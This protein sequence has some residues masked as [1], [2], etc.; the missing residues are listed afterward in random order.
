M[1]TVTGIVATLKSCELQQSLV[2]PSHP[3]LCLFLKLSC[4]KVR[5]LTLKFTQAIITGDTT[6]N[7]SIE[8]REEG[9]EGGR[10]EG[11]QAGF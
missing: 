5:I 3:Q 8:E 4:N 2:L 1:K 10:K 11:R 6:L 9:R 7:N